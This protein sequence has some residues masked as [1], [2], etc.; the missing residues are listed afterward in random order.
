MYAYFIR[1]VSLY[2][3]LWLVVIA[4]SIIMLSL[5]FAVLKFIAGVS[6]PSAWT[7][8]TVFLLSISTGLSNYCSQL[9]PDIFSAA[10]LLGFALLL[11][12]NGMNN[13]WKTWITFTL[14]LS[15]MCHSS[16]LLMLTGLLSFLLLFFRI[17]KK[18]LELNF[19]RL[20]LPGIAVMSCWLIIPLMN[21]TLDAGFT[22]SRA[23]NVFIMGRLTES[24][25]LNDFL[26]KKCAEETLPLC[27]YIDR[28][29]A[30]SND[31]LW[32]HSSP[33]Y[34]GKC[35]EQFHI[36]DCWLPKNKE[37]QASIHEI[38]STPAYLKRYLA[39]CFSE[40]AKQLTS[41]ETRPLEPMLENSPV[42]NSVKWKF[43]KDYPSYISSGQSQ[44]PFTAALSNHI[45]PWIVLL[46]CVFC[47]SAFF[48]KEIPSR[49]K[50]LALV[51]LIGLFLNAFV[52]A[53]LSMVAARF[54]GRIVWL[55]PLIF[56]VM[57]LFLREYRRRK[58]LRG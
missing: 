15:L 27:N 24:G 38:L 13:Y 39:F 21:Y 12:A 22:L 1:H 53:S 56:I 44:Q 47:L 54:Q 48:T 16:N 4:Q 36:E 6:K 31:F 32:G 30:N 50:L 3:T 40:T 29:P 23:P 41:F 55:L 43:P 20:L 10:A 9:M 7:F 52:C 34:E 5:V 28:L 46:S 8:V 19:R 25:V 14:L 57:I 42:I 35:F 49:F 45:L 18:K 2:E 33:L 11:I 26:K 37:Y 17:L 58:S 51:I